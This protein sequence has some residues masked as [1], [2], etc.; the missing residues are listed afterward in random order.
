MKEYE[1]IIDLGSKSYC[2]KAKTEE[3]AKKKAVE[4]FEKLPDCD[5]ADEYWVG[6]CYE[7]E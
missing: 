2:I 3:E 5:K 6:D 7:V 4:E 1:V